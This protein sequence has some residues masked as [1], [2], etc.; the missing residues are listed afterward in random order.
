[1]QLIFIG[2]VTTTYLYINIHT[3]VIFTFISNECI[4]LISLLLKFIFAKKI[5]FMMNCLIVS[6][7]R[8]TLGRDVNVRNL[9]LD[10]RYPYLLCLVLILE[11]QN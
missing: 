3:Y 5:K 9:R 4:T 11:Q 2:L 1:M 7:L 8:K 10:K 6:R